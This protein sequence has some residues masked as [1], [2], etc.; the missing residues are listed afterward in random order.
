MTGEVFYVGEYCWRMGADRRWD[1]WGKIDM[2][3]GPGW[4]WVEL[5][6]VSVGTALAVE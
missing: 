1:A 3:L 6:D 5:E 2:G 4:F